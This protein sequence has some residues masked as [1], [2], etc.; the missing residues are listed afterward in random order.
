MH[1]NNVHAV[2]I[3][4]EEDAIIGTISAKDLRGL[5]LDNFGSLIKPAKEFAKITGVRNF[6]VLD[7]NQVRV[8]DACSFM[9]KER[10][11]HVWLTSGKVI[12]GC[13]TPTDILKLF[14]L[15]V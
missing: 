3:L 6:D 10:V 13:V 14:I 12:T 2:P 9:L 8:E 5:T 15:A 7:Q 4:N 1:I 11:H